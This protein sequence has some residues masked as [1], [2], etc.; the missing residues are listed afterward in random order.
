VDANDPYAPPEATAVDAELHGLDDVDLRAQSLPTP[1]IRSAGIVA[2]ITGAVFVLMIVQLLGSEP[3]GLGGAIF[4]AVLVLSALAFFLAA[5]AAPSG[6]VW[7]FVVA[8]A[9]CPVAIV[10][11]ILYLFAVTGVGVVGAVLAASTLT[12]LLLS[13]SQAR[14]TARAHALLDRLATSKQRPGDARQGKP[15]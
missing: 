6:R 4:V 5:W 1:Q 8:M 9:L 11:S 10:A 14:R 3:R 13:F 7:A 12:M 15:R 2:M